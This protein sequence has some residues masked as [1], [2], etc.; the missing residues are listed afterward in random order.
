ML[1]VINKRLAVQEA[2]IEKVCA[3]PP[4]ARCILHIQG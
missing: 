1:S 3:R 2:A 4:P